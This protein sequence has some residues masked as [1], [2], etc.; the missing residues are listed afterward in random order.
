MSGGPAPGLRRS[1]A[2]LAIDVLFADD[3]LVVVDKPAGMPSVPARTPLD[4]PCVAVV[5]A[6]QVGI[7]ERVHRVDRD[8]SGI[9]VLARSSAARASLGRAFETRQ[10]RKRYEAIVQGRPL[11]ADG[12]VRLPLARDPDRPPRYRVDPILGREATTRWRLLETAVTPDDGERS[13][14]E[15]E[16]V[17]GRS[18]QLRVHLAWLGLPIVGDRL[19]GRC[20]VA[21]GTALLLRAVSTSLRHPRDGRPLEFTAAPLVRMPGVVTRGGP[22]QAW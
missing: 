8:T 22:R 4:P 10:V 17:T 19:Y 9:L 6:P 13:R 2:Q 7:L 21:D 20:P 1:H 5:L 15:L 16:P 3:D 18:H 12:E 14:L 11:M